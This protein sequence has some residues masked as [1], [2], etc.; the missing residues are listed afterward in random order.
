MARDF[1]TY[2]DR[3]VSKEGFR[4]FIYAKDGKQKLVNSWDEF[5]RNINTGEWFS[6]K[7]EAQYA[8]QEEEKTQLFTIEELKE[9]EKLAKADNFEVKRRGRKKASK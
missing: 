3:E 7:V 6:T 8:K 5:I 4:V 2:Q 9:S 1:V